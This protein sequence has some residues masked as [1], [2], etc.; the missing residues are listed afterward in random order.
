MPEPIPPI[1][2]D[3]IENSSII[4]H[5]EGSGLGRVLGLNFVGSHVV[6]SLAAT[7]AGFRGVVTIK[8]E[9]PIDDDAP[10]P[11]W[12]TSIGSHVGTTSNALT[13][14]VD[15]SHNIN[16]ASGTHIMPTVEGLYY[17]EATLTGEITSNICDAAHDGIGYVLAPRFTKYSATGGL[18]PSTDDHYCMQSFENCHYGGSLSTLLKGLFYTLV[19]ESIVMRYDVDALGTAIASIPTATFDFT[20]QIQRVSLGT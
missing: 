20:F 15:T 19:G 4:L 14:T 7:E 18:G 12:L 16:L 9:N 1:W 3:L 6:A 8:S 2:F 5:D 17:V 13:H 10:L 11:A